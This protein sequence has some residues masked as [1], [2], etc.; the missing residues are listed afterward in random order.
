[1]RVLDVDSDDVTRESWA[2][3]FN[4]RET[5]SWELAHELS[6]IGSLEYETDTLLALGQVLD[7]AQVVELYE[8]LRDKS[9]RVESEWR[10][11]FEE[12]FPEHADALPPV[13]AHQ[14]PE[15]EPAG[16]TPYETAKQLKAAVATRQAIRDAL[17]SQGLDESAIEVLLRA[18]SL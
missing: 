7:T 5:I 13:G 4:Q 15:P 3:D 10:D 12:F 16:P 17:A 6:K 9:L 14:Q 2:S 1:M 8:Y 18:L 11:E